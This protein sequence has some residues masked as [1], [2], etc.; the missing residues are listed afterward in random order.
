IGWL[1]LL[2]PIA[3]VAYAGIRVAPKY[4]TYFKISKAMEQTAAEV[5]GDEQPN[6]N[7]MRSAL[8]SRFDIEDIDYPAVL[9]IPIVRDG[10]HWVMRLNYEETVPLFGQLWLLMK[11][12]KTTVIR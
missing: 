3:I 7:A 11:F 6:I 10:E 1:I 9:D 4:M 8:Q 5:A 2:V 12:D